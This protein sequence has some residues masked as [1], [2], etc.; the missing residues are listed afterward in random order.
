MGINNLPVALFF[1]L[2]C[3]TWFTAQD[4]HR[5]G[6]ALSPII[7]ITAIHTHRLIHLA[8][9]AH[10]SLKDYQVGRLANRAAQQFYALFYRPSLSRHSNT[11]RKQQG[12]IAWETLHWPCFFLAAFEGWGFLLEGPGGWLAVCFCSFYFIWPTGLAGALGEMLFSNPS[13]TTVIIIFLTVVLALAP[14]MGS[15]WIGPGSSGAQVAYGSGWV[16]SPAR[17]RIP[18]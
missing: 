7:T 12:W 6:A 17:L 14:R 3:W 18:G 1:L 2:P 8:F 4:R 11:R 5:G 13:F 10:R 15:D 16:G 9:T